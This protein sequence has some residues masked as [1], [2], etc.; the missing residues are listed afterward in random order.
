MSILVV[1]QG[2]CLFQDISTVRS[3]SK[4]LDT[5][6]L[7]LKEF[8]ERLFFLKISKNDLAC[9]IGFLKVWLVK[10]FVCFTG[11]SVTILHNTH[12]KIYNVLIT[13]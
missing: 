6:M 13:C 3:G 5:L 2:K 4:R 8:G 1:M 9:I 12:L 7:F 11:M 10:L